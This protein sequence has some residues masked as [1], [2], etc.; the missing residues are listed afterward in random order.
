MKIIKVEEELTNFEK[1]QKLRGKIFLSG[2]EFD[3][4]R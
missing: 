4:K 3:E 1:D 2:T